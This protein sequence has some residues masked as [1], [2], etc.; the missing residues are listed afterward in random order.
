MPL[1]GLHDE[2]FAVAL[3]ANV[4]RHERD[5]EPLGRERAGELLA[6]GDS[7]LGRNDSRPFR[8]EPHRDRPPDPAARTGYDRNLPLESERRGHL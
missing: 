3:L 2:P 1:E 5:L 7:P 6:L 4:R 8:R